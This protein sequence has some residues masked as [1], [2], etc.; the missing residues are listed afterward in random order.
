M[1]EVPPVVVGEYT[2]PSPS[3]S[4]L[5][6]EIKSQIPPPVDPNAFSGIVAT[7]VATSGSGN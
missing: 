2:T 1:A 6:A 7:V 3:Q 4:A 5:L